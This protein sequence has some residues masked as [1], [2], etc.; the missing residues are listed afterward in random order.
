MC[1]T[2]WL[3]QVLVTVALS[4]LPYEHSWVSG[5]SASGAFLPPA[6]GFLSFSLLSRHCRASSRC[7]SFP[8]GAPPGCS[9]FCPIACQDWGYQ[10]QA[11]CLMPAFFPPAT[12]SVSTYSLNYLFSSLNLCSPQP[13]FI[14]GMYGAYRGSPVWCTGPGQVLFCSSLYQAPQPIHYFSYNLYIL[15]FAPV[16]SDLF[17]CL[18]FRKTKP[19][20]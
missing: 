9:T 4:Y 15:C 2:E 12:E 1:R 20:N 3:F 6:L 18:C 5:A 16:F 13:M 19:D 7:T 17:F 11:Q 10:P 8:H 14:W